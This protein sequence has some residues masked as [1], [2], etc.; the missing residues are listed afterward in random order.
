MERS[1]RIETKVGKNSEAHFYH[2]IMMPDFVIIGAQKSASTFVHLCLSEHPEVYIPYSETPFFQDPD[3]NPDRLD[4]LESY[5]EN[6]NLSGVQC[7]GIKRPDYL[8]KPECPKRMS[9]HIPNA[10]LIAVLRD[11]IERIISAYYHFVKTGF[12]PP[13]DVNEGLKK[14]LHGPWD[15]NHP[16]SKELVEY[17][18]YYR[19]IK[20]YLKYYDRKDLKVCMHETISCSPNKKIREMYEFLN[21]EK[22]FQPKKFINRRPKSSTYDIKRVTRIH[23]A[24]KLIN[25]YY[26]GKKRMKRIPVKKNP[27]KYVKYS[28]LRGLNKVDEFVRGRADKPKLSRELSH[29]LRELYADDVRKLESLLGKS[30]ESWTTVE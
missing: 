9:K 25:K 8:A 6:V 30:L 17:G 7:L 16:R 23:K 3:Y 15:K 11:P 20:R 26:N 10:K 29:E 1:S 12:I 27:L 13:V 28:A 2:L 24:N 14:V 5:F 22:N 19:H 21:V 4:I 18:F